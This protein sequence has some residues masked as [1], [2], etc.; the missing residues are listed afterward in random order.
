[1]Y[2]RRFNIEL[3]EYKMEQQCAIYDYCEENGISNLEVKLI[4][5]FYL[6][7]D[8]PSFYGCDLAAIFTINEITTLI[9]CFGTDF[10]NKLHRGMHLVCVGHEQTCYGYPVTMSE[11]S[12]MRGFICKIK[13]Q[14]RPNVILSEELD[15]LILV[16]SEIDFF[17]SDENPTNH[18]QQLK[19]IA[20]I[21][22]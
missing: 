16:L 20:D 10:Q 12:T 15:V 9:Q 1:M 18:V 17:G 14:I 22:A 8:R 6:E 4:H 5:L 7:I 13:K 21:V 2:T 19:I 3:R 11:E